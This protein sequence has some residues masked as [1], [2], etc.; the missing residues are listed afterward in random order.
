MR[1]NLFIDTTLDSSK[2]NI[3]NISMP[4]PQR[5]NAMEELLRY[6]SNEPDEVREHLRILTDKVKN[7]ESFKVEVANPTKE[8]SYPHSVQLQS[9]NKKD[10]G[11]KKDNYNTM[12]VDLNFRHPVKDFS[13][14]FMLKNSDFT[15]IRIYDLR[16]TVLPKVFKAILEFETSAMIPLIQEL[17]VSN[18]TYKEIT[19]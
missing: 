17:P 3:L 11:K 5:R 7:I 1:D 4:Y 10:D 15:D 13:S 6:S 12:R 16:I 19:F 2:P 8:I 9:T 18:P 14:R